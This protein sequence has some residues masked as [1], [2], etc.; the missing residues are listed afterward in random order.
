[1]PQLSAPLPP[2]VALSVFGSCT[3]GR[4]KALAT[5]A[6]LSSTKEMLFSVPM[7]FLWRGETVFFF[8]EHVVYWSYTAEHTSVQVTVMYVRWAHLKRHLG[9]NTGKSIVRPHF[10]PLL[11]VSFW[12]AKGPYY[13]FGSWW[14]GCFI[15]VPPGIRGQVLGVMRLVVHRLSL[16]MFQW[17]CGIGFLCSVLGGSW[18]KVNP[19]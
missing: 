6:A 11:D 2:G 7:G 14:C 18:A 9:R 8:E 17:G 4:E 16:S 13:S 10:L 1:M 5:V 12:L 15:L 3:L 19:C